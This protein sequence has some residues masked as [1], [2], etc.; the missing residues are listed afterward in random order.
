MSRGYS[1]FQTEAESIPGA[2]PDLH[3]SNGK[4]SGPPLL[5]GFVVLSDVTGREI[6]RYAVQIIPTLN[7]PLEFPHVFETGGRI[8]LNADWH[9]Y[10]D[11]HCCLMTKPEEILMCRKGITLSDF[12]SK[13]VVPYFFNQKQRELTG[14]FEHERAH[15][16][17][18]TFQFFCET[19]KTTD[20]TTVLKCLRFIRARNEPNRVSDCFCGARQKYRKCHKEAYRHLSC[21]TNEELDA[22]V[23]ELMDI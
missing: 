17:Q 15:G 4:G 23:L 7:Y 9:V 8:P 19:L 21:F 6:D 13:Q 22:F 5:E 1:V 10:P 18:G 3:L 11:G 14:F 20:L 16:R 12:I 2:F